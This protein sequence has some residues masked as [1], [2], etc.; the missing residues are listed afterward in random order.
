MLVGLFIDPTTISA[1]LLRSSG[2][3]LDAVTSDRTI[4]DRS[5][6]KLSPKL[7]FMIEM[8]LQIVRLQ[9]K[10]LIGTEHLLWGLVRLAET[11]DTNAIKMFQQ[12]SIDLDNLNKQLVEA[13]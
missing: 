2:M 1:R 4:S 13:V 10:K 7:N 5:H 12:Y 11:G 3:T 6:L 9:G 8:A